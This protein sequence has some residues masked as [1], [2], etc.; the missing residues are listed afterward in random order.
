MLEKFVRCHA[1]WE[2]CTIDELVIQGNSKIGSLLWPSTN[3]EQKWINHYISLGFMKRLHRKWLRISGQGDVFNEAVIGPEH[4][5]SGIRVT[6][7]WNNQN[8]PGWNGNQS[9]LSANVSLSCMKQH[10]LIRLQRCGSTKPTQR[11]VDQCPFLFT[12]HAGIR[13]SPQSQCPVIVKM[14]RIFLF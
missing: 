3:F 8:W 5:L 1:E 7:S 9:A 2:V 12:H 6:Q 13:I 14:T 11:C 4:P 10:L